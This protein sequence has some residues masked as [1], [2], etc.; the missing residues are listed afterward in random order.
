MSDVK[1]ADGKVYRHSTKYPIKELQ[2]LE[3]W[4][5]KRS[6]K[7]SNK[8]EIKSSR[9]KER[10]NNISNGLSVK[11]SDRAIPLDKLSVD[12]EVVSNVRSKA[13][14]F[15][16]SSE[17]KI[18]SNDA[19]GMPL[20]AQ[21]DDTY[22]MMNNKRKRI[23]TPRRPPIILQEKKASAN[24]NTIIDGTNNFE[25]KNSTIELKQMNKPPDSKGKF[26]DSNEKP[27]KLKIDNQDKPKF[28]VQKRKSNQLALYLLRPS[29]DRFLS[30][31]QRSKVSLESST[32]DD[33][34]TDE[35]VSARYSRPKQRAIPS[36][37][38]SA[39]Q[40]DRPLSTS[41]NVR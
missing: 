15:N 19:N 16:G 41:S 21:V 22:S 26:D 2:H 33:E 20:D 14:V 10:K 12:E 28:S 31:L 13:S 3:K 38:H 37:S 18:L 29:S 30:L 11:N 35:E 9:Q 36:R 32:S 17:I 1:E 24:I 27:T 8:I 7:N 4:L 5:Q 25:N 39:D 23:Q 34:A 40:V 6:N